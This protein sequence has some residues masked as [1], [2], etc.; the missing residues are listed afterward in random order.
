MK[1]I[2]KRKRQPSEWEKIFAN[3]TTENGLIFKIHKELMLKTKKTSNY[4]IKK[5]VEDL[6]RHFYKEDIYRW[7][8]NI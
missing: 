2:K 5:W 4:P 3:E 6:N 7:L 1:T 8:T